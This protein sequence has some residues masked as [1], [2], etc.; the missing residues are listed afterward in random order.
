[1]TKQQQLTGSPF[2][3]DILATAKEFREA[4]EKLLAPEA[5]ALLGAKLEPIADRLDAQERSAALIGGDPHAA[6][7]GVAPE[8]Q[9]AAEQFRVS[10][11]MDQMFGRPAGEGFARALETQIA[12][13]YGVP[14]GPATGT[15]S[16]AA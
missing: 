2:I 5:L 13:A 14:Q 11:A 12:A 15:P 7:S 6:L 1:M 8:L 10:R 9:A 4:K 3:R 16:P